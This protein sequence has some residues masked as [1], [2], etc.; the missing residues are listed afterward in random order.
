[1]RLLGRGV[2]YH[3]PLESVQPRRVNI[4]TNRGSR[5]IST[6]YI[7]S[8]YV[9]ND[10]LNNQITINKIQINHNTQK[11]NVLNMFWIFEN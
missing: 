1:M 8:I 2:L 9:S 4:F 11:I 6:G 10:N 3:D 5:H 7:K